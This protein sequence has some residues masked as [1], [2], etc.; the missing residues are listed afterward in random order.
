MGEGRTISGYYV[1][2]GP[3]A[4]AAVHMSLEAIDRLS[5]VVLTGFGA[6]PRR[7]A[8][9]GGILIG[10][11]SGGVVRIE[12]YEAVAC[13]YK[14][15]PSYLLS[16]A[17]AAAFAE[18]CAKWNEEAGKAQ[19][20]VGYYRSNTRDQATISEE[21]RELY[22]K[23][24]PNPA[25]V[26]LFI[27]PYASKVS[28]AG[29]ITRMGGRLEDRPAAEFPFR[30]AEIEGTP[31]PTRRPPGE[32][33]P[34]RPEPEPRLPRREAPRREEPPPVPEVRTPAP[35]VAPAEYSPP[36]PAAPVYGEPEIPSPERIYAVT[37]EARPQRKGW[38]WLPFSFL[39]LLLGILL[40]F[41][42]ALTM[43]PGRSGSLGDDPF[44]IE[45]S[46]AKSDQSLHIRWNRQSEAI[47]LAQKGVLY[48]KDGGYS[49]QVDLD[50]TQLQNGSV[51][52]R[53]QSDHVQFRFEVYPRDKVSLVESVEW[54]Q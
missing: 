27:R 2:E 8:E 47:R 53:R 33:R 32:L 26:M 35:A 51:I 25:A 9:V 10:T 21:D 38:M 40:G 34:A 22:E 6:I 7:G 49:K 48:I 18:A 42:A 37:T 5:G 31:A 28:T 17:D 23:Y 1:W 20:A 46:V 19:Y 16:D 36:A 24:F 50:S 41:Q 12:D 30:R 52:Y 29:F 44:N 3:G 11:I 54:R 14:R 45:L 15:G 4:A 43:Y 13:S 39:F